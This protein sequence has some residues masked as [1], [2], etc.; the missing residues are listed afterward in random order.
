M[1]ITTDDDSQELRVERFYSDDGEGAGTAY[2]DL[3]GYI[4]LHGDPKAEAEGMSHHDA[5]VVLLRRMMELAEVTEG[6]RA[7][8]FG[9]GP[10]GATACMAESTGAR[11]VGVSSSDSLNKQ[12]RQYVAERG[13]DGQV[14]FL[15]V[16]PTEYR[17]FNAFADGSFDVVTAL[18]SLCHVPH[19]EDFFASVRRVLKPGGRLV[20]M[21]WLQ[22]P[23]GDYQTQ[24]QI[25]SVIGPVCE[26]TRLAELRRLETYTDLVEA[27][28]F[29]VRHAEDMY[30]GVLCLGSTEPE[31]EWQG[32]DA[33][34]GVPELFRRGKQALDAARQAGPFTVGYLVA[35]RRDTV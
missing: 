23:F 18:E 8:D 9:S 24:E 14:S 5:A 11:F 22:R 4:W 7:L 19:P 25:D 10:G 12:A 2:V 34:V 32:Y 30:E 17:Q 15:T 29:T 16:G 27:A 13:L 1:T 21:D 6:M 20:V 3:M 33:P 26:T 35:V 28:G 31:E